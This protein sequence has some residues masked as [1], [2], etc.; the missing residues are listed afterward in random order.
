MKKISKGFTIIELIISICLFS[1]LIF[2]VVSMLLNVFSNPERSLSAL[3]NIDIARVVA[4]DFANEVRNASVA[5]DGSYPLNQA[6]ENQ[7]IFYSNY[8]SS[9]PT[10]MNR[11]R[12]YVENNNLY[13]GVV[14]PSGSPLTYNLLSEEVSTLLTGLENGLDPAFYYYDG[15]YNG[16]GSEL[17]E[18]ISLTSVK[19]VKI[20]LV[21][22]RISDEQGSTFLVN[23]GAAIRNLKDNL[24]N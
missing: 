4:S 20:N 5:N 19:F 6:T 15:D 17:S 13:K 10:V 3:E 8:E 23:A 2:V 18:P 7:I 24:G 22:P 21:T 14:I 9:G 11:I 16:S 12:Y 1:I